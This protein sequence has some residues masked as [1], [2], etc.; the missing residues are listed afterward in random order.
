LGGPLGAPHVLLSLESVSKSFGSLAVIEGLSLAVAEGEALGVIGPNGAGKT[1]AL[2]L[3]IGRLRPDRG[4]IRFA[5]QDVTRLPPHARCRAGIALTHQIPHPFE[6][7]SVFEN[8]LVGASFG[9]AGA[10]PADSAVTALELTGLLPKANTRAGTLTLL[11]RKR[12]ELARALATRPRV[13]LLDEIA[14]GLTDSELPE[15]ISLV[16]RINSEGVAIVWIEHIVHALRSAVSRLVAID[17]GRVLVEGPP[18]DVMA[19]ADVQRVYLGI[20][21]Q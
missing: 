16:Q 18:D 6:A 13:L 12:L 5:G 3:M 4:T 8:V 15:V 21:V 1:T 11:E 17:V 10:S 14:G 7:L 20:D 19:N 9:R 2:N